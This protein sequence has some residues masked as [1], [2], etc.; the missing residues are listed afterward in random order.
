MLIKFQIKIQC[1]VQFTRSKHFL[2]HEFSQIDHNAI[3]S[4]LNDLILDSK[5][6]YM[7]FS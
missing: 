5:N 7:K 2:V 6:I 4:T 1:P 3:D